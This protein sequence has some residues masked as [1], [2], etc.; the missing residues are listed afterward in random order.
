MAMAMAT[1]QTQLWP[2]GRSHVRRSACD[3]P[4]GRVPASPLARPSIG[5]AASRP[6]LARAATW[7]GDPSSGD[8]AIRALQWDGVTLRLIR[9]H[10]IT[11]KGCGTTNEPAGNTCRN[12]KLIHGKPS[13]VGMPYEADDQPDDPAD[14]SAGHYAHRCAPFKKTLAT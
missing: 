10:A 7:P 5:V 12:A 3:R 13:G 6:A 9:R 11:T 8:A 4:A 1:N 14:H 2:G